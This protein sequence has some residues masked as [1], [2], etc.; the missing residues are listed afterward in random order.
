MTLIKDLEHVKITNDLQAFNII[1]EHLLTQNTRSINDDI[2]GSC[3]Y[4][5]VDDFPISDDIIDEVINWSYV[6]NGKSCAVGILIK[7]DFYSPLLEDNSVDEIIVREALQDSHPDWNINNNNTL[8]MLL[9]CQQIHDS[10][11]PNHWASALDFLQGW[12]FIDK[13]SNVNFSNHIDSVINGSSNIIVRKNAIMQFVKAQLYEK[14]GRGY[15][16]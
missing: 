6:P 13:N 15:D 2:G 11:I 9:C 3:A 16:A 14:Y 7:E 12:I 4:R 10:I 5:G 8:I 1:K